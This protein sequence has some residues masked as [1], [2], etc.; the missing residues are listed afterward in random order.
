M[1]EKRLIERPVGPGGSSDPASAVYK[2]ELVKERIVLAAFDA[3]SQYGIKSI[4][5]DYLARTIGI[6][7]RTIYDYFSDKEELLTEGIDYYALKRQALM[8]RASKESSS[9]PETIFLFYMQIM[10]R[11]KWF[12]RKFYDDLQKFPKAV[13]ALH[14]EKNAFSAECLRLFRQGVEEGDFT[15]EVNYEIVSLLLKEQ[16]GMLQP[17]KLFASYSPVEVCDTVFF[18]FLRGCCTD[19]G[20][21][22]LDALIAARN[23]KLKS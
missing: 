16:P 22:K 20:R 5:M 15:A 7:K 17:S 18:T 4:S 1:K 14:N 3:F 6:S 23:N 21:T 19:A 11:P 12:S 13:K 9:V 2:D 10:E 8:H